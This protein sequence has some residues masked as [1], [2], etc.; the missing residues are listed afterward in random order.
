MVVTAILR[1]YQDW[2]KYSCKELCKEKYAEADREK[3]GRTTLEII[4]RYAGRSTMQSWKPCRVEEA[5]C[6]V[7]SGA[8][9]VNQWTRLR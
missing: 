3:D 7:T 6:E 1:K 9:A 4:G 5:G 2:S 8:P